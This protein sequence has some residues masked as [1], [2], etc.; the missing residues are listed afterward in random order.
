M[1]TQIINPRINYIVEKVNLGTMKNG[2]PIFTDM[3]NCMVNKKY[4]EN[5]TPAVVEFDIA[6]AFNEVYRSKMREACNIYCPDIIKFFDLMYSN[7]S[8]VHYQ[9]GFKIRSAR[10]FQ[11]GDGLASMFSLVTYHQLHKCRK[12]RDIYFIKFFYDDGRAIVDWND[13]QSTIECLEE[14]LAKLGLRLNRQKTVVYSD[15]KDRAKKDSLRSMMGIEVKDGVN[16]PMLGTFVGN[17]T[18]TQE[19]L[20]EKIAEF[21]NFMDKVKRIE[22]KQT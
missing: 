20:K 21:S 7:H 14:N 19:W 2:I 11:Q 3:M 15:M 18:S 4:K 8:Y 16:F 1:I 5:F 13:I 17:K 9:L 10:G 22:S 6:N 12:F